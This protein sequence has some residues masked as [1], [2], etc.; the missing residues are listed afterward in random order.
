[1]SIEC[2]GTVIPEEWLKRGVSIEIKDLP[3]PAESNLIIALENELLP[4]LFQ[5]EVGAY[6]NSIR[7]SL[8]VLAMALVKRH[9]TQIREDRVFFP[10]AKSK[11][12]FERRG[13][14]AQKFLE[15]LPELDRRLIE[16]MAVPEVTVH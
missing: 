10:I 16:H 2:T 7:S 4:L 11:E 15:G 14:G 8:D 9:N 6:I 13:S 5:A 12:E 3:P 1:M